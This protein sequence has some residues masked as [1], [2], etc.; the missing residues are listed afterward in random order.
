MNFG[1]DISW[2]AL[3]LIMV[4]VTISL[5]FLLPYRRHAH[6]LKLDATQ[7][8]TVLS[9]VSGVLYIDDIWRFRFVLFFRSLLSL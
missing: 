4:I 5:L 7:P 2:T 3:G 9:S 6:V 8:R 1:V